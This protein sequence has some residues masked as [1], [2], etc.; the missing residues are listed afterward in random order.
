MKKVITPFLVLLLGLFTIASGNIVSD[1]SPLGSWAF[2]V[3]Q[4]PWEYHR[5]TI[6]FEEG[7]N[8]AL[9]GKILFHTGQELNI[10]RVMME[11]DELTF[12][13]TVDGYDVRSIVKVDADALT[14]HVVTME[15]NMPFTAERDAAEEA[16]RE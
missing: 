16:V 15:G 2:S 10:D 8:G 11:G 3:N 6:T 4:A 5:G 7:E 9:T 14:G 1:H 12:D 13:V